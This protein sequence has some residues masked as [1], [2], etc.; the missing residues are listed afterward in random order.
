MSFNIGDKV[1]VKALG[2]GISSPEFLGKVFTICH[3][4]PGYPFSIKLDGNARHYVWHEDMLELYDDGII[5]VGDSVELVSAGELP[6]ECNTGDR[7]YQ[8]VLTRQLYSP[9]IVDRVEGAFLYI[10]GVKYWAK[11]FKKAGAI[12]NPNIKYSKVIKKIKEMKARRE[13]LGYKY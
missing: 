6:S 1:R 11:R 4:V 9:L 5:R 8:V 2:Y 13:K 10:E 3:I 12:Q 7:D